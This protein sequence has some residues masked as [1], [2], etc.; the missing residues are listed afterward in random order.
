LLKG[1]ALSGE[2]SKPVNLRFD[3]DNDHDRDKPGGIQLRLGQ[4]GINGKLKKKI[5]YG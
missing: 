4:R 3:V 2:L 1:S 5:K